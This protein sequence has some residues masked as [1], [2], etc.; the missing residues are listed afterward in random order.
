MITMKIG[1]KKVDH[2][3]TDIGT[4]TRILNSAVVQKMD[5]CL[6]GLVI[7]IQTFKM[8]ATFQAF[9]SRYKNG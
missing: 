2:T 6:F 1:C 3:A 4:H 5:W 7:D 8:D 9:L